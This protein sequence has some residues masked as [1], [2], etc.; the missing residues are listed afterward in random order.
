MV[1]LLR[2]FDNACF[3]QRR[4]LPLKRPHSEAGQPGKLPDIE[5]LVGIAEK[6]GKHLS[7]GL[8]EKGR[9]GERR[10]LA[11][12][13]V[14]TIVLIE[15]TECKRIA[16]AYTKDKDEREKARYALIWHGDIGCMGRSGSF[17][18]YI[19]IVGIN[20]Y[21][22]FVVAPMLSS[23]AVEFEAPVHVIDGMKKVTESELTL[24]ALDWAPDT[25]TAAHRFRLSYSSE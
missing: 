10:S 13:I 23:P 15:S 4:K 25:F 22:S 24:T 5:C 8:A 16:P 20:A 6:H 14:S 19:A 12:L 9:G 3:R 21:D 1:A 2:A 7:S 18:P 11:V 17:N